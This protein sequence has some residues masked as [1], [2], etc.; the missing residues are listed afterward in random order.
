MENVNDIKETIK[1]KPLQE[2]LIEQISEN[3]IEKIISTILVEEPLTIGH[4]LNPHISSESTYSFIPLAYFSETPKYKHHFHEAN[5]VTVKF[6]LI[7]KTIDTK[8]GK[9][10]KIGRCVDLFNEFTVDRYPEDTLISAE[11]YLGQEEPTFLIKTIPLNNLD[12][13][14]HCFFDKPIKTSYPYLYFWIK[15][16]VEN[17]YLTDD[18]DK[19]LLVYCYMGSCDYRKRLECKLVDNMDAMN[20]F[21]KMENIEMAIRP[22]KNQEIIPISKPIE[23]NDEFSSIFDNLS[24][25][26]FIENIRKKIIGTLLCKYEFKPIGQG[27][28][29]RPSNTTNHSFISL[30]SADNLEEYK[31]SNIVMA[32]FP[33]I[34]NLEK[35]GFFRIKRNIDFFQD[36]TVER[37]PEDTLISAELYIAT[38]GMDKPLFLLK[39][40]ELENVDNKTYRFFDKPIYIPNYYHFW[41]KINIEGKQEMNRNLLIYCYMGSAKEIHVWR[42]LRLP[43]YVADIISVE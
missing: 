7:F 16:N 27:L 5:P 32:K 13:T 25:E 33:L 1:D 26:D 23:V 29:P 2:K 20:I 43:R 30:A 21:K 22:V 31:N 36:F 40:I 28:I 42:D 12:N 6:P 15:I 17:D 9:I 38:E 41:I 19:N 39:T 8:K 14:K 3:D 34:Y 37:Y 4:G 35:N 18:L 24:N 11:L 10:F